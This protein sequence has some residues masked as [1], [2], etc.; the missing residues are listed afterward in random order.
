M[1]VLLLTSCASQ[2]YVVDTKGVDLELY[3]ADL[4][5]CKKY[6]KQ[7][8]TSDGVGESAMLGFV[9]G[10]ILGEITGGPEV[11]ADLAVTTAIETG[12]ARAIENTHTQAQIVKNCLNNRGYIVLN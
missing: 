6:G 5:E 12:S 4:N 1:T 11:S 3:S 10:A 8:P 2:N 9:I 7:L